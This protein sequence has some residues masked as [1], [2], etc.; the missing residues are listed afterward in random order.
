VFSNRHYSWKLLGALAVVALLGVVAARRGDA[1][2]PM[3]WRCVAEPRRWEDTR[4]WIPAA[5]ILS[6]QDA[7]YEIAAGDPEAR[8]R[9]VGRAP[10]KPGDL[11][12]L[13]GTFRSEGPR[14]E[15]ERSR[16]YPSRFRLRWL[17]EIVSVAVAL[18]VLAN[19]ARHFLFRPR[20]LQ[21]EGRDGG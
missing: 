13:T 21:L 8:V 19:L 1:I 4:L 6:V 3:L 10:G 5:R 14:I 7:G 12:T 2:N 17:V 20:L 15:A 11:I 18:A 16:V 9:V